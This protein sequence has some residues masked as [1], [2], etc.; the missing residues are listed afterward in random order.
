MPGNKT[1]FIINDNQVDLKTLKSY[2]NQTGYQIYSFASPVEALDKMS[3]VSPDLIILDYLMPEMNG[4]EFMIKISER[5]L[6]NN[7]WQV[8]LVTSKYFDQEEKLSMLTLGI[9]QIFEKPIKKSDLLK[10]INDFLANK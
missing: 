5:L 6:Q 9:T 1:I 3:N 10:S 7:D 8:Y 2:V 4:D